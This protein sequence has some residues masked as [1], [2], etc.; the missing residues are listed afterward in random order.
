[1][2][3]HFHLLVRPGVKPLS[4]LMRKVLTGY[5]IYFNCR[6]KR[7]GYLYQN[8]YKS[9]LCQ[10]EAY[11]LELIRY[12]HLNPLRARIVKDIRELNKYRWS[13]HSVL[14]G[15]QKAEFQSTGEVLERFGGTK[16]TA[17]KKYLE[18]I[19][20]AKN[21]GK[22]DDLTGGGLRRSAGGWSGVFDL[23]RAK[24]AWRGDERVLGDGEF[25]DQV[26]KISEE[27][28]VKK[29]KLKKEGWD[30]NRAVKRACEIMSIKEHEIKKRGRGNKVSH[31]RAL[32]SYWCHNELGI[33]G[34]EIAKYFGISRPSVSTAIKRGEKIARESSVKLIN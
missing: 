23:K 19:E 24:E 16:S 33:S 4:D 11:L 6:H 5:A 9:I 26:L 1:M 32:T 7:R 12:V 15:E 29:E 21:T 14:M 18:F 25:V 20:A 31:A 28:I 13:G 22:R 30:I 3:N 17:I 34:I 27:G 8:R 2:P 10:E